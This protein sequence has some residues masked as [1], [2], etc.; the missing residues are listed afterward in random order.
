MP[1][2]YRIFRSI[3]KT[4]RIP[5]IYHNTQYPLVN[6]SYAA[7]CTFSNVRF[8]SIMP[9]PTKFIIPHDRYS[10]NILFQYLQKVVE[11][12]HLIAKKADTM[13]KKGTAL[14]INECNKSL[15]IEGSIFST[16]KVWIVTT[17]SAIIN[18]IK[19]IEL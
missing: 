2:P 17:Q 3:G 6:I 15:I 8:C 11:S 19:S 14:H 10:H 9:Y 12:L 13:K 7:L 18:F 4:T 1:P 5:H 16:K